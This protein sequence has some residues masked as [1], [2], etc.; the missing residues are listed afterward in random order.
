M[1]QLFRLIFK[2]R[3]FLLFLI[4]EFFSFYLII[5]NNNYWDVSFFNTSSYYTAKTLEASNYVKNYMNLGDVND[6]LIAE[7]AE[8]KKTVSALKQIQGRSGDLY[9][10][11]SAFARRFE[12]TVAKVVNNTVNLT[13]NYLTLDKGR[14][15]GIEPGDG[16]V[17][18]QGIVGSVMSCSD[19]FSRVYSILHS[20][21]NVSAEV[22]NKALREKSDKALGIAK[23]GG[24]NP[25]AIDLT[26][27]DRS[28]PIKQGD[29]VVTSEQNVV[30]PAGT[31]VG[32]VRK[33]NVKQDDAFF[34]IEVELSTDFQNI[35]YVYIVKNRLKREQEDLEKPTQEE[36]KN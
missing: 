33:L 23:W 1:S 28:K 20:R 25:R 32:R 11:D 30:Y 16:V 15:H 21:Q 4:F 19:H 18:P 8:L 3:N 31:M 2:I 35:S 36:K 27:I 24:L 22:R 5:K 10:V 7:N 26:T 17:C 6:Q 14:L 12:F 9:K 13:N 34:N 29:S